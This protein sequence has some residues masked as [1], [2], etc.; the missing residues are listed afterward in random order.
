VDKIVAHGI[1]I[2]KVASCS[3]T[4]WPLLERIVRTT[5]PIIASIAGTPLEEVDKVVSFL[6]HRRRDFAL[7]HCVAE[8]PTQ[9]RN[10]QLNQIGLMKSR[11]PQVPVGFSTH[12][13]PDSR[14]PIKI[15]I[16][17]GATIYEKH[18]G[19]PMADI[20]LNA[21]SATPLEVRVWLESAQQALE[22]CGVREKRHEFSEDEKASLRALRR[23]VFAR[24]PLTRGERITLNDVFFAIPITDGQLTANDMSKYT[25]FHTQADVRA[26]GP[27][28][29]TSVSKVEIREKISDVIRRVR[30]L[31]KEAKVVAPGQADLEVSHHYGLDRFDEYGITMITV[32]NR[33]YCKK[34][35]IV[36]P[37]Q[38]HPEQ[39]H[40]VKEETFH[41]LWGL[42][43]VNLDGVTTERH[44]GDL[45]VI[46]PGVKHSFT[47]STGAI[48]EEISSTHYKDDSYYTDPEISNNKNRKS[49][50]TYWL[51]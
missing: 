21:Y 27:L 18:V 28:L 37:G 39:Y 8:Y 44:Q 42:V 1:D 4:D 40:K 5:K 43:S 15:A 16:A 10:L 13:P 51:E 25:E 17:Q 19:V 31:L 23:G 38:K 41:I 12:E 29:F 32:V 9:P 45:V 20:P 26:N 49:L 7:M 48:I 14:D 33:A 50:L 47:S 24:R 6:S 35:I 2:I 3:L 46:E 11:Y 36:L 30:A 22:M 34:L